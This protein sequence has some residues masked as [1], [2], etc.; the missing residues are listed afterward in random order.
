M[1]RIIRILL[2]SVLLLSFVPAS[3]SVYAETASEY[4]DA[5]RLVNALNI[6]KP[7]DESEEFNGNM[8]V[9]RK[10]FIS[11]VMNAYG[12]SRVSTNGISLSFKDVD[13]NDK[14]YNDIASAVS[15]DIMHGCSADSFAP[16]Q[17]ITILQ[18]SKVL[19]H[20]LGYDIQAYY[21][22]GYPFGYS[23]VAKELGL[24]NGFSEYN[25]DD[26]L[27]INNFA[28]LLI[29][30]LKCYP[31][32][33][34]GIENEDFLYK[35]SY[36]TFAETHLKLKYATGVVMG[37]YETMLADHPDLS[38]GEIFINGTVYNYDGVTEDLIGRCV[39]YFYSVDDLTK[40]DIAAI[41]IRD[42]YYKEFSIS[43]DEIINADANGISYEE[44]DFVKSISLTGKL[45]YVY[46]GKMVLSFDFNTVKSADACFI[47]FVNNNSDAGY[48]IVFINNYDTIVVEGFSVESGVIT[49]KQT[50]FNGAV[51][52]D[53]SGVKTLV[54]D[55]DKDVVVFNK[56]KEL[57]PQESIKS[58]NVIS[59]YENDT[60][61]K[62]FLSDAKKEFTASGVEDDCIIADGELVP[63]AS[64]VNTANIKYGK[65]YTGSLDVFGRIV[66]LKEGASEDYQIAYLISAKAAQSEFDES[67]YKFF[68]EQ[69]VFETL[70]P[71]KVFLVN[72]TQ[73]SRYALPLALFTDVPQQDGSTVFEFTRQLVKFK[74]T[75][76]GLLKEII[77]ADTTIGT[78]GSDFFKGKTL[79][80]KALDRFG[81]YV[82]WAGVVNA[83]ASTLV[84]R[85]P[86]DKT[87]TDESLF[88]I[89]PVSRL[90][91]Q[92]YNLDCYY[93]DI[94]SQMADI[95][96]IKNNLDVI[97][98]DSNAGVVLSKSQ[99]VD[100][101]KVPAY[102]FNLLVNNAEVSVIV[103]SELN[104]VASAIDKGDVIRYA[105][106]EAGLVADIKHIYDSSAKSYLLNDNPSHGFISSE[107][108]GYGRLVKV[109]D[110]FARITF[111]EFDKVYTPL[112]TYSLDSYNLSN[113]KITVVRELANG[114]R[115]IKAGTPADVLSGDMAVIVTR[116]N[117]FKAFV[118]IKR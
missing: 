84:F 64:S 95:L 18:A 72:G 26:Y 36:Y 65:L 101:D 46:N 91:I 62:I 63:L 93:T 108:E 59:Y 24:T 47:N 29:N 61:I 90:G 44:T 69:G 42:E 67:Y 58:N 74:K 27:T 20:A 57:V 56:N 76:D 55:K 70:V 71:A 10:E 118:V 106:N 23:L 50:S 40:N 15:M 117:I 92:S 89:V 111:N 51:S 49:D 2:L 3:I 94:D 4:T 34:N 7:A 102:K 82:T 30:F 45:K 28:K 12:P 112:E 107:R 75:N 33:A 87:A 105:V 80:N 21:K 100:S 81:T 37:N 83:D 103:K 22:G 109:S 96:V 104:S 16:D 13:I 77:T 99:I 53:L 39:N 25:F 88:E 86:S 60:V 73:Q 66:Y 35:R 68:T 79:E 85:V 43:S 113:A 98:F 115:I 78:D 14:Y 6:L 54:L 116:S 31:Y 5:Y 114:T 17:P 48:D 19:V 9:L 110:D 8:I 41:T 1:K 38:E 11:A 32:E 97:T 52:G